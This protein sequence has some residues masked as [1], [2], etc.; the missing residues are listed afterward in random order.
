[1][2][3]LESQKPPPE[4]PKDIRA[5]PQVARASLKDLQEEIR[6]RSIQREVSKLLLSSINSEQFRWEAIQ[7]LPDKHDA[8]VIYLK[9]SLSQLE[10]NL[11]YNELQEATDSL[12]KNT[13]NYPEITLTWIIN[14]SIHTIEGYDIE[15]TARIGGELLKQIERKKYPQKFWYDSIDF[16]IFENGNIFVW[17][18][19]RDTIKLL[20]F[21]DFLWNDLE[22]QKDRVVLYAYIAE[23]FGRPLDEAFLSNILS[24]TEWDATNPTIPEDR[25]IINDRSWHLNI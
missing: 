1:M 5:N 15:S 10:I 13:K 9:T 24:P 17:G 11:H 21:F 3:P 23:Y 20:W 22:S 8:T 19:K 18:R 7:V 12:R 16:S 25:W 6:K 4:Q 14:K 2:K